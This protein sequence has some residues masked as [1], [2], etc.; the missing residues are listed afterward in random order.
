MTRDPASVV[1][2]GYD[3]IGPRY[4]EGSEGDTL[5]HAHLSRALDRVGAGSLVVDLGC[6]PGRQLAAV[7]AAG[8][9]AVGVDLSGAQLAIA[10]ATAPGAL[11]VQGDMTTLALRAGSI[12]AVVSFFATGHLPSA[13]HA[14]F[15]ESVARLLRPGGVY[16][17]TAPVV[18]GDG[19]EDGWLGVP[20]F[21]GGIGQE[22]TASA[23]AS[24]G[25]V[26]ESVEVIDEGKGERFVWL[27]GSKPSIR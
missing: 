18:G 27:A 13:S 3:A 16:V 8:C 26:V 14:P 11:L 6:G 9:T 7:C 12:D 17:G 15:Y 2:A 4:A 19:I 5:R 22:A 21:F 23:V 25:L 10:R 1:R 20:M 24:A